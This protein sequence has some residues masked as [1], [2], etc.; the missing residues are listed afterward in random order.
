L[1]RKAHKHK[2]KVS[3][4]ATFGALHISIRW[5]LHPLTV[6][7]FWKTAFVIFLLVD[8]LHSG[9]P[10]LLPVLHEVLGS[11]FESAV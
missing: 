4:T 11:S 8:L 5:P 6:T 10:V 2:N 9:L 1:T 3:V 7:K